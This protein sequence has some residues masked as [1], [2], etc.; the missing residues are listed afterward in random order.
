MKKCG[1]SFCSVLIKHNRRYC[2]SK[3]FGVAYS[4]DAAQCI[5]KTRTGIK[6]FYDING[7]IPYKLELGNLYKIARKTFGTWNNAIIASG[8]SPNPVKFAN[9]FIAKDGHKVDSQSEKII[10]DWFYDHKIKHQV[11]V[12]YQANSRFSAD[13]LVGSSLIEFFGIY[14][15]QKRYT[16]LANRKIALAKKLNINLIKLFPQD[17]KKLDRVLG[18]YLNLN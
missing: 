1:N 10:D 7:R 9:R 5:N 14:G 8:F 4:F 3:C 15:K 2:S 13:F 17:L 16:E 11:H 6:K 18:G 12:L